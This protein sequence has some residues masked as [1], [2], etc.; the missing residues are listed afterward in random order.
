MGFGGR[1]SMDDN[2]TPLMFRYEL[3]PQSIYQGWWRVL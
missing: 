1:S 3:N 2:W